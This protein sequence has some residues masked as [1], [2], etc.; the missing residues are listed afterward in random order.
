SDSTKNEKFDWI[1]QDHAKNVGRTRP[2]LTSPFPMKYI[3]NQIKT[4]Q[5][6][7]LGPPKQTKARRLLYEKFAKEISRTSKS[8]LTKMAKPT[9]PKRKKPT[10]KPIHTKN[11]GKKDRELSELSIKDLK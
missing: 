9:K 8:T 10:P 6:Y 11:V 2:G 4:S 7:P 5:N 1:Q 3:K